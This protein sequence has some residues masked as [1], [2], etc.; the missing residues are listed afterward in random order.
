MPFKIV[1]NDITKM[2]A[3]AIVN[4]ANPQLK[5]G[6]GV[7]GA[8]FAAAG[9]EELQR[10]CDRIGGCEVGQAVITGAGRLSSKYI[11]HTVGPI[12]RGGGHG[13]AKLLRDSYMN[14]LELAVKHKCRSIAF[15]LISSGIYGYPKDRALHVAVSSIGEFLMK[16]DIDV[17]L[18]VFDRSSY[19]LSE[20]LFS[21]IER[22]IDDNYVDSHLDAERSRRLTLYERQGIRGS[23]DYRAAS[24]SADQAAF[25]QLERTVHESADQ[26][27]P[28]PADQAACEP[29]DHA[30]CEPADQIP[31]EPDDQEKEFRLYK[32]EAPMLAPVPKRKRSLEDV[33]GELDETFSE[34]LLRLID[35]KGMTDVETYKRANIDRRLFSKIRS[36]KDY[37]PSKPTAIALAIAL[38]LSLDET[39]DL[40]ARAGYTLSFSNKFDVIIRYFIEEG[41]YNIFEIN[42]A[43]FAFEQDLLGA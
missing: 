40:L 39:L 11:I 10:E 34:M 7:C 28:E 29:E 4:A 31:Y 8:I 26:D 33:V 41:N 38:R 35:E 27:E 1:R 37:N 2:E 3:D 18:V 5:M 43:L 15:P 32:T 36:N 13:E 6:G 24:R 21:A 19:K 14:S 17:Y 12:W 20:K 25:E 23:R 16:N 30:P 9:P 42:Q 22:Y